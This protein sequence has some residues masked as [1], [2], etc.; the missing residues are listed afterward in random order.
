MKTEE[1][2]IIEVE[3]DN[4]KKLI[5]KRIDIENQISSLQEKINVEELKIKREQFLSKMPSQAFGSVI[6]YN[7]LNEN[8]H[9]FDNEQ[10]NK[11]VR[12]I[13]H[14]EDKENNYRKLY[15][16]CT[17]N[18]M[19]DPEKIPVD[20][21]NNT[22]KEIDFLYKL[23]GIL[24]YEVNG[25]L[26]SFNKVYNKLEDTGLFMSI[27]EKKSQE[28]LSQISNKLSNVMES[29]KVVFK[30]LENSNKI[31]RS[32]DQNTSNLDEISFSLWD[33]SNITHEMS[34]KL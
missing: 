1:I 11:V 34:N 14:I 33:M 23:L 24:I 15:L 19:T 18:Y 3:I 9:F 21:L 4:N 31:L 32:I 6:L 27:P 28:F 20:A 5:D 13:S 7:K 17:K 12:F 29:L 8:Y 16:K 25:D 2:K 30:Q 22:K 10:F 26:V